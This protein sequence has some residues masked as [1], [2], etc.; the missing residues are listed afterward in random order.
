MK[1]LYLQSYFDSIYLAL[2]VGPTGQP[3]TCQVLGR[4]YGLVGN[5]SL[6]NSTFKGRPLI[7]FLFLIIGLLT[8]QKHIPE[9][10]TRY[11]LGY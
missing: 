1:Q 5:N 8:A 2:V 4:S 7:S 11:Q 6:K 3:L 9:I 10:V